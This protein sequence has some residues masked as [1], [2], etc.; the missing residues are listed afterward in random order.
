[1]LWAVFVMMT[2]SVVLA[3]ARS[4]SE[5]CEGYG[6]HD[7]DVTFYRGLLAEADDDVRCGLVAPEDVV[8]TRAEIGRRL[9]ASLNSASERRPRASRRRRPR[10]VVAAL[11]IVVVL[12]LVALA[13]YV[14]VGAPNQP[15][16]P[17]ASRRTGGDFNLATAVPDIHA[18]QARADIAALPPEQ[19][20]NA[21]REMVGGLA[22]RLSKDGRD[23]QGWLQLIRSYVVLGERQKAEAAVASARAQLAGDAQAPERIDELVRQLGLKG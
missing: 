4:L 3:L 5:R 21:I 23:L 7:S 17:I 19:R 1:V 12:P 11:A 13:T 10:R 22:E 14:K 8:A 16:M 9:L 18:G 15:D 2:S 20:S 6:V